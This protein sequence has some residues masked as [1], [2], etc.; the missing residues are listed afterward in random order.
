MWFK[1]S[2]PY[3]CGF[4]NC[5][6]FPTG[7]DF[8]TGSKARKLKI[9]HVTD[10]VGCQTSPFWHKLPFGVETYGSGFQYPP[11]VVVDRFISECSPFRVLLDPFKN[12]QPTVTQ[13]LTCDS[14]CWFSSFSSSPGFVA[15]TA[16]AT[17]LTGMGAAAI[18][19]PGC[20]PF[21]WWFAVV[22][23]W[24]G[25]GFLPR[26]T[27]IQQPRFSDSTRWRTEYERCSPGSPG[28][29]SPNTQ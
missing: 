9:P 12:S 28:I 18:P 24:G 4:S 5:G 11:Q 16:S 23:F 10:L 1:D 20:L 15:S 7:V 13:S 2:T 22:V 19:K 6:G 14:F 29:S 25:S 3:T 26:P 27:F 21:V 8:P 17:R